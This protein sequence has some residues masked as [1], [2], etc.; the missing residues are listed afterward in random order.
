MKRHFD[1]DDAFFSNTAIKRK[2]NNR[3]VNKIILSNIERARIGIE[4]ICQL[5]DIDI[6]ISSWYRSVKLNNV[7]KGS[8]TGHPTGFCIDFVSNKY[9]PSQLIEKIKPLVDRLAK[10]GIFIDQC[11]NEYNRWIHISFDHTR[12]RNMFFRKG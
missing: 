6:Y 4:R 3:T 11:I 5:L 12:K 7:V 8:A 1:I 9:S 2:I 10:E